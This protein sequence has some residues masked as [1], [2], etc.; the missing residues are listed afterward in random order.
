MTESTCVYMRQ[1]AKWLFL[2]RNKKPNDLNAG[3]WIGVGGK[4]KPEE[5]IR[6]C[7]MREVEEETGLIM[8]DLVYCGKIYFR[9]G[10][11]IHE[12]ITLYTCTHFWGKMHEDTEG[13]LAWIK[14]EDILSLRLWP[15]DRIFLWRILHGS[16]MPFTLEMVYDQQ[17]NLLKWTEMEPEDE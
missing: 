1:G 5:T 8:R 11:S 3:Y 12:K 9:M 2:L 16:A 6:A 4:K 15:G 7:A 13:S 17:G 10:S 14:E